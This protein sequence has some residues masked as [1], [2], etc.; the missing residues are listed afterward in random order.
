MNKVLLYRKP[1]DDDILSTKDEEL[2]IAKNVWSNNFYQ[3]RTLI[4]LPIEKN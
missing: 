4:M 2:Y 1:F 3:Y